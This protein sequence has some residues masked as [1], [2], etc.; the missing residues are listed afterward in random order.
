MSLGILADSQATLPESYPAA[1]HLLHHTG[2]IAAQ[3]EDWYRLRGCL[4]Q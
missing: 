3:T 1:Q 4:T 2:L